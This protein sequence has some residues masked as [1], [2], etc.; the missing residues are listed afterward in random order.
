M[1][2]FAGTIVQH[3]STKHRMPA[4]RGMASHH[5]RTFERVPVNKELLT[6][7]V[8]VNKK[9]LTGTVPVNNLYLYNKHLGNSEHSAYKNGPLQTCKYQLHT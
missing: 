9:L 2:V 4:P 8:P 7:T 5:L 6:G 1:E 3:S